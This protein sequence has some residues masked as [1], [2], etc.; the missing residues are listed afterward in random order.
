V[1]AHD[2]EC[3]TLGD[4]LDFAGRDDDAGIGAGAKVLRSGAAISGVG[5]DHFGG[6]VVGDVQCVS[7]VGAFA[8]SGGQGAV[9]GALGGLQ[10]TVASADHRGQ[11][12]LMR[13][14]L[15]RVPA[16]RSGFTGFRFPSE[17]ITVAVRSAVRWYLRYGLS[18]RD[19]EELLAERG[20]DHVL[21]SR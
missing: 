3:L 14:H 1:G 12:E 4:V 20:N 16:P 9:V 15:A 18:Y 10:G 2:R 6:L 7:H 19:L 11:A 13:R 8:D 17:V 5:E 21:S